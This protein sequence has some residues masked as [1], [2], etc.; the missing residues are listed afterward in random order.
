MV[1]LRAAT[2]TSLLAPSSSK[3]GFH[4]SQCIVVQ[5]NVV[6]KDCNEHSKWKGW[7]PCTL[8]LHLKGKY[9]IQKD[10]SSHFDYAFAFGIAPQQSYDQTNNIVY[11]PAFDEVTDRKPLL[12]E[13][14]F[15]NK[16][17]TIIEFPYS[18]YFCGGYYNQSTHIYYYAFQSS[19]DESYSILE[20][21]ESIEFMYYNSK[22]YFSFNTGDAGYLVPGY[23]VEIDTQL[24]TSSVVFTI[25]TSATTPIN[26]FWNFIM[27]D[28]NGYITFINNPNLGLLDIYFLNLGTYQV[29]NITIPNNLPSNQNAC[30]PEKGQLF[31]EQ[32]SGYCYTYC[33]WH[34]THPSVRSRD[35]YLAT[36]A[37]GNWVSQEW[38]THQTYYLVEYGPKI[39]PYVPP[40]PTKGATVTVTNLAAFTHIT[41]KSRNEVA[42]FNFTHIVPASSP[43]YDIMVPNGVDIYSI[44]FSTDPET[45]SLTIPYWRYLTPQVQII[46]PSTDISPM[47][48][49]GDHFGIDPS[50]LT[51][52]VGPSQTPCTSPSIIVPHTLI[53]C[54][55]PAVNSTLPVSVKVGSS[56]S[57]PSTRIPFYDMHSLRA[58]QVLLGY[59][60]FTE[61]QESI[62]LGK[63]HTIDSFTPY[64]GVP[65]SRAQ[66]ATI[67]RMFPWNGERVFVGLMGTDTGANIDNLGGPNDGLI[68]VTSTTC[69]NLIGCP[70][71][72]F[73]GSIDSTN[74]YTYYD[75][76][77]ANYGKVE[78]PT[79]PYG[80]LVFYGHDPVIRDT[81]VK[82]FNTSGGMFELAIDNGMGFTYTESTFAVE[83]KP[84]ITSTVAKRGTKGIEVSIGYGYGVVAPGV[85]YFDLKPFKGPS[86]G[87]H[88]PYLTS[89]DSSQYGEVEITGYNFGNDELKISI[90]IDSVPCLKTVILADHRV[91]GC[92][93]N[94]A[95]GRNLPITV[96]VGGQLQVNSFK[97]SYPPIINSYHQVGMDMYIVGD[98]FGDAGKSLVTVNI[99]GVPYKPTSA[100]NSVVSVR[101]LDYTL[102]GHL[103]VTVDGLASQRHSF[104]LRPVITDATS[105][106]TRGGRMV[107]LS[108][109]FF[110]TIDFAGHSIH[111]RAYIQGFGECSKPVIYATQTRAVCSGP[112]GSGKDLQLSFIVASQTG[113]F[114]HFSYD[115]PTIDTVS[116]SKNIVSI[117]GTN[118][119][120]DESTVFI[121]F[122]GHSLPV[123]VDKIEYETIYAKIPK[124]AINGQLSINVTGQVSSKAN[125]VITPSISET[126]LVDTA[127]GSITITGS[128]FTAKRQNG[129]STDIH[130]SVTLKG[131]EST[132]SCKN[133]KVSSFTKLICHVPPGTGVSNTISVTIDGAT[134]NDHTFAYQP[135]TIVSSKQ[136]GAKIFVQ[137]TQFGDDPSLASLAFNGVSVPVARV[138]DDEIKAYIPHTAKSGDLT[139]TIDTQSTKSLPFT[140]TP[141]LLSISSTSPSGGPIS[142][143]G[144]WLDSEHYREVTFARSQPCAEVVA[145]D[146]QDSLS[147]IQ[148]LAPPGEGDQIQVTATIDGRS[149][150]ITFSYDAP[151]L[152]SVV[153]DA[154]NRVM[155]SGRN[156]GQDKEALTV[157][158]GELEIKDFKLE[159]PNTITFTANSNIINDMV[160]VS[161]NGRVSQ[162][163]LLKVRPS[164]SGVTLSKTEGSVVTITGTH[165]NGRRGDGEVTTID[166]QVNS[167]KQHC[168]VIPQANINNQQIQC[169]A[170]QGT[171]LNIPIAV[172]IDGIQSNTIKTFGYLAPTIKSLV[173]TLDVVTIIGHNFGQDID[174]V[175]AQPLPLT[176]SSVNHTHIVATIGSASKN[177]EIK[178]QVNS[179]ASNQIQFNIRPIIT[180]I[181]SASPHGGQVTISG[182]FLQGRRLDDTNTR[183]T[184]TVGDTPLEFISASVDGRQ[185][186]CDLTTGSFVKSPIVVTIDGIESHPFDYTSKPPTLTSVTGNVYFQVAGNV[187]IIGTNFYVTVV[188]TIQGEPCINPFVTATQI[189]CHYSAMVTPTSRNLYVTVS[190]NTLEVSSPLFSYISDPCPSDCSKHGVCFSGLC[191]C[192]PNFSGADCS[193]SVDDPINPITNITSGQFPITSVTSFATSLS[194]LHEIDGDGQTVRLVDANLLIW[195][196]Q[197]KSH[198]YIATDPSEMFEIT[199]TIST[200]PRTESIV[201][202]GQFIPT[203]P[204]AFNHRLTII[205]WPFTS[206]TNTLQVVYKL[207]AP[208]YTAL[209]ICGSIPTTHTKDTINNALRSMTID[210]PLATFVSRFSNRVIL[211]SLANQLDIQTIPLKSVGVPYNFTTTTVLVAHSIPY[212]TQSAEVNVIF[213]AN[214]KNIDP[215]TPDCIA[216]GDEPESLSDNSIYST[217]LV[218]HI[219][220]AAVVSIA[221][222]YAYTRHRYGS[223]DDFDKME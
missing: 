116:N 53:T 47:R 173:Q 70:D 208:Q 131:T 107:T 39:E 171:G 25:P 16:T 162:K 105:I 195:K 60:T 198:T 186:I 170:P 141:H 46:Y 55:I 144:R 108:G 24:N 203:P 145:I 19:I 164:I 160:S 79:T 211:D 202:G 77:L 175:T 40:A 58:I 111:P 182:S 87:F 56:F 218:Y 89:V 86:I 34:N 169:L 159:N 49:V 101:M 205:D 135:P 3:L 136:K 134:S 37:H 97:F 183:I 156:F 1:V 123:Q 179:Q 48:L 6:G 42:P 51:I 181:T 126:S 149:D 178:V 57:Y 138:S 192:S 163:R 157:M 152:A 121:S 80:Q 29:T 166:V 207:D 176:I 20:V 85:L 62:K 96:Q 59:G 64:H 120:A 84:W 92:M 112:P 45:F 98:N 102:N 75:P 158:V 8:E 122:P 32:P 187:T 95:S 14:D 88:P 161:N 38:P 61:I 91:I 216:F 130:I 2:Y 63:R 5:K 82:M 133:I 113:Y 191:R 190:A 204:S 201:F 66:M 188:V 68:A 81:S 7:H 199:L 219:S 52:L 103:D 94:N 67:K 143:C 41:F 118:F 223:R 23:V 206:Q 150:T 18:T 31:Y 210:T 196:R 69:T 132:A 119:G 13:F 128:H 36:D 193:I 109:A 21:G 174:Q 220:I 65:E 148:C 215:A 30:G 110:N 73:N 155:I 209:D 28:V 71:G 214:H 104:T 129:D 44:V 74:S 11:L 140:L 72:S 54:L 194:H 212:F 142:I 50:R 189:I 154:N 43:H 217:N 221:V 26:D 147:C 146:D 22:F 90:L 78:T 125:I 27:D 35:S 137:G 151:D 167:G 124:D 76:S 197:P 12:V 180:D 168:K 83:G 115:P 185:M 10:Y 172:S 184:I 17:Q 177:T 127:G 114:D 213:Q 15:N 139:V 200:Y 9:L 153:V 106:P 4:I 117:K 33:A 93:A 100:N 165:L 222:Y 99:N